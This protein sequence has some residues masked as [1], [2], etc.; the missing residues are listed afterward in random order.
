[1]KKILTFLAAVI[2]L[3]L[4]FPALDA[5]ANTAASG[6]SQQYSSLPQQSPVKV[7]VDGLPVNFPDVQPLI[8]KI[9][10]QEGGRTLVPF[11]V[12]AEV[13]G[14]DVGWDEETR[15]AYAKTANCSVRLKIGSLE[16]YRNNEPFLLDVPA[17]II[18]NRTMVPV[19]FFSESLHAKVDWDSETRTVIID[20][21]PREMEVL[22]FYAQGTPETSSWAD[23]FGKPFPEAET[24]NTDI[25][26]SI[27]AGW[28]AADEHGNL[29][30]R[31][32]SGFNR[33]PG[34]EKVL[35]KA[36]KYRVKTEMML[37]MTDGEGQLTRLL[38]NERAVR[39]LVKNIKREV[40]NYSGVNVDFEGL[41]F[42]SE[43]QDL[44]D[45]RAKFNKFIRML[46]GEIKNGKEKGAEK[47]LTVTLHAP[48]SAY[49]GYDYKTIG[50]LA[51]RIVVMAYDYGEPGRPEPVDKVKQAVDLALQ[52]VPPSKLLLGISTYNENAASIKAKIGLAK[53]YSLAGIAVWRLGLTS[54]EEWDCLRQ[55]IIKPGIDTDTD[56]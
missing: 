40:K 44:N 31:H 8:E 37:H 19:R 4:S 3:L 53:R 2:F 14:A 11:R 50:E 29:L 25:V 10:G 42:S 51:D 36:E 55:A 35:E 52:E 13:L 5:G 27:A 56:A 20:S 18:N 45:V 7:T 33:P 12:I 46:A 23:L 9:P 22:G 47:T 34:Y 30:T 15:T 6:P 49:R 32:K 17:K 54:E 21:P 28:F 26:S 43:K 39:R 1:M 16:A 24:G 41:G 48:N 38:D